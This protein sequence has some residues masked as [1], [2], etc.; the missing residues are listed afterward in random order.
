MKV[1]VAVDHAGYTA[2]SAVIDKLRELGHEVVDLGT[3]SID[4]VDY[5]DYAARGARAVSSGECDRAVLVCGTGVGM[6]LAANKIT[7]VRA[8]APYDEYTTRMCRTHNDTNVCCLGAR[9]M[10]AERMAEILELW[11]GLPFEGGGR[12]QRRVEKIRALEDCSQPHKN[13]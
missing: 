7:G 4:P 2:K 5:P 11:L 8:A 13:V 10:S 9:N 12:H 1:A 6:Q 3:H